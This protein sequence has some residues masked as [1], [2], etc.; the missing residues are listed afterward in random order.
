MAY[1]NDMRAQPTARVSRLVLTLALLLG[2]G[3]GQQ[4][5]APEPQEDLQARADRLA[6]ESIIVDTH[7][8]VPYR[9][10]EGREDI[11][12]RTE[13]GDFDY[14]RAV[15]GGLNAPFMSIYT[16][17][18]LQESGGSKEMAD[19][20]IDLVEEFAQEWPDKFSLARSPQD[21]RDDF[22]AG[23]ISLPMGM[24]N[25]APIGDDLA[26]LTYFRD[27]GISYI[28]L[29]HGKSN[30]I[31]D[32]SYDEERVWQGL[33]PFGRQV[34]TEMNRLGIMIDISHVTD[35]AFDQVLDLTRVP[36]IASHSSCR[37]FT[38]DWERNMS[39]EM[40]RRL[41]ENG[42]VI[43][44]NFGSAFLTQEAWEASEAMWDAV[45]EYREEHDLTEDDE[46][47]EVFVETY[48]QENPT[49]LADVSDVVDHIDH[50]VEL[51]GIDHVGIGSDFDGVG[52]STPTGLKD[53]SYYPSLVR[54][55]LERGYSDEDI[56]K[57]LG[58]NTLRVWAEVERV[59][60]EMRAES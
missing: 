49:V 57:I 36:V 39:D 15:L 34:V 27:R 33:S 7:I 4:S 38:G 18:D 53:V 10:Q 58:E 37:S 16:P 48:R 43:H 19:D 40:I 9:M 28:T 29:T 50:A 46:A 35:E 30:Q 44:I 59:A 56:R 41:G 12:Q 23:L 60:A 21:V 2:A 8:D 17:A 55:L 31:S 26:K 3:C 13:G 5:P 51:A 20:L 25:G 1:L 47:V 52:P 54:H 22:D 32:S 42:G 24:E 14:P 6:R 45:G 11:S